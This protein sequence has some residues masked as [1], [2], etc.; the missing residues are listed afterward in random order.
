VSLR[1]DIQSVINQHS[2]ENASNTPDYLLAGFL[3]ACLQAFELGVIQ[4]DSFYGVT[5]VPGRT[6]ALTLERS[7]G[8]NVPAPGEGKA[9]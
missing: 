7:N 4:R 3:I 6:P 9:P 1:D 2:R 5:L 8:D